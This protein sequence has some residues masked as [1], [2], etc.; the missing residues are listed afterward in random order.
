MKKLIL[1]IALIFS[2]NTFASL[3]TGKF[4]CDNGAELDIFKY[5]PHFFSAMMI[6][7]SGSGW[8]SR[9]DSIEW[10][11]KRGR[12]Y[13]EELKHLGEVTFMN[14][15]NKILLQFTYFKVNCLRE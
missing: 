4:S 10:N 11:G 9:L 5:S 14:R 1:F 7:P 2:L 15:V 8:M 3:E 12:M 13:D 6:Y